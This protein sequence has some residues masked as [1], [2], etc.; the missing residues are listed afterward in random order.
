[1]A[2]V[3][4]VLVFA[5]LFLLSGVEGRFF[6]PL[7]AAYVISLGASLLVAITVTPVLCYWLLGRAKALRHG[8]D[9][10]LVRV[11]KGAY[12]RTLTFALRAKP[13]V[14]GVAV[15]LVAGAV[16]LAST[17]GSSFLPDFNEGSLTLFLNT[18]PGT[19]LAESSR[20]TRRVELSVGRL[21]GVASSPGA[22]VAP[23]TTARRA[24]ERERDGRAPKPGVHVRAS[25]A[26]RSGS[27][28]RRRPTYQIG[29]PIAHRL[30]T[31]L[32]TPAAS[33]SS[34]R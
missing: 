22:P 7:G 6:R 15:A 27:S 3:I 17:F 31:S 28:P 10:W 33:R 21:E 19:S 16:L 13:L 14:V 23:G 26:T 5:P 8:R 2:T 9:G 34:L 24:G 25:T 11:L 18:P 20:I 30:P 29:G 1:V 4:I 32:G 12:T